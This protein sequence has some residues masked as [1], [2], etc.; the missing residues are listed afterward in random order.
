MDVDNNDRRGYYHD[1]NRPYGRGRDVGRPRD[2][3]PLYSD[4][5]FPRQR[6]RGFP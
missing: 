4:D 6:G 3:R 5:I 2:E 1:R